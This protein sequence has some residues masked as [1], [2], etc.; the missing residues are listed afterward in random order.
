[1]NIFFILF[2]IGIISF[3]SNNISKVNTNNTTTSNDCNCSHNIFNDNLS[4][5]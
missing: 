3:I 4:N 1:M 2:G 5:F